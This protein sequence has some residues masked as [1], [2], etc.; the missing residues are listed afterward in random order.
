MALTGVH[1]FHSLPLDRRSQQLFGFF[2]VV[3]NVATCLVYEQLVCLFL[4]H[5]YLLHSPLFILELLSFYAAMSSS[6]LQV[7]ACRILKLEF[8]CC[9]SGSLSSLVFLFTTLIT[10][11]AVSV[12]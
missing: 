5:C 4:D 8:G 6:H 2:H 12:L 1:L 11:I 7:Q 9:I 3:G 10:F